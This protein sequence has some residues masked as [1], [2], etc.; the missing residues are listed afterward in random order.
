M[1]QIGGLFPRF[2]MLCDSA[3]LDAPP[4]AKTPLLWLSGGLRMVSVSVHQNSGGIVQKRT[5]RFRC[6]RRISQPAVRAVCNVGRF[7]TSIRHEKSPDRWLGLGVRCAS[8]AGSARI[9][10]DLSGSGNGA[11]TIAGDGGLSFTI[12]HSDNNNLQRCRR[13]RFFGFWQTHLDAGL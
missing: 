13:R 6:W 8:E 3:C 5:A 9:L 10:F 12:R 1:M 11:K 2:R 7:S 4:R